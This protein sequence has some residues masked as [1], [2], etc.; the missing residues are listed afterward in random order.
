M[1]RFF[2]VLVAMALIALLSGFCAPNGNII[3]KGDFSD[4]LLINMGEPHIR[5]DLGL[6]QT[7]AFGGI[8]YI[9]REVWTYRI[10]DYN[11]RFVIENGQIVADHWT[12]F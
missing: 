4:K 6:V 2:L 12:R 7:R 10:E 1:K 8:V 5:T 3:S 11:Y 9:K